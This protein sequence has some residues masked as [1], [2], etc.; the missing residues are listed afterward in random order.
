MHIAAGI[1][2]GACMQEKAASAM[3]KRFREAESTKHRELVK[4][5]KVENAGPLLSATIQKHDA[6]MQHAEAQQ[7]CLRVRLRL[8]LQ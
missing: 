5:G 2:A 7:A 3:Q 4:N 6:D 8:H 1:E